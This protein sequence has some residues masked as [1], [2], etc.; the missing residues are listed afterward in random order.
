LT[1]IGFGSNWRYTE[2][3]KLMSKSGLRLGVDLGGTKIE[4]IVLDAEG[5][6]QC[7]E[8]IAT[9]QGDYAATLDAV[10]ALVSSLESAAG[11]P[12]SVG[13]GMPGSLSRATGRVKNS[14]SVCLNGQP[15]HRELET[16]LDRPLRFANDADCFALSEAS[17]GAGRDAA[18]VFGVIIGTGTGG[19]IVVNKQLLSGPNGIAGEW[20]HNPLP[21][22]RDEELPGPACYCGLQGCIE[23]WLSGP[24]L[25]C[26]HRQLYDVSLDARTIIQLA[27]L[28]DEKAC[29]SMQRY[30][31]R[32]ARALASVINVLDPDVIVLGGGLSNCKRLYQAVMSQWDECVF[33]DRVDTRLV[34]A[35]HG[36][37]SGVRGA[38]RLWPLQ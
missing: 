37:T 33:S 2:Y 17:D 35:Q 24:G 5:I 20:G 22:P 6:E 12:C 13:I 38:A 31:N 29:S 23:T 15:L 7:R 26:D 14:N 32:M 1:G 9:P 16:R 21:W 28:G 19:G 25:A 18:V 10:V 34:Q 36:D 11:Q 27:E 30:A 8:R 4:G 3:H